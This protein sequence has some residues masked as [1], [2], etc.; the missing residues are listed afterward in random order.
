MKQFIFTAAL[1]L[2]M[3][4]QAQT[5]SIDRILNEIEQ[6]NKE[7]KA[8]E[9]LIQSQK[10]EAKTDNNLP[11]PTVSY[12]HLW[13]KKNSD[14]TVS[15]MVISQ[16]FDFPTLY[17]SRHK[18]NKLK[19]GTFDGQA[20]IIRR[21]LLLQAKEVCLDI[22][23]LRRQKLILDERLKNAQQLSNMYTQRLEAGDANIIE[24]NKINLELLNVKTE[25]TMN[26]TTLQNKMKE[27]RMLN[28]NEVI[29]FEE[30][31]Y[32]VVHFPEN[33]QELKAEVIATDFELQSINKEVAAARQQV[34]VN[35]SQWL[36]KLELGYR[37]NTE[38]GDPFNG[39]VVGFSIPI[40]EN[41]N[42]VKMAKAQ[43]LNLSYQK[44]NTSLQIESELA[45]LYEE[46][47]ALRSSM[48][49]YEKTFQAQSD[50]E[51][52]KQALTGGEISMIEYFVEVS[53]IY[54]SKLN[55]LE[56]QNQ[57]QKAMAKI[58]RNRL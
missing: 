6:N 16:S 34:T 51:L 9:S 19:M 20:D 23:M 45:Q 37:R 39:F 2:T 4:A 57:Y 46:A 35:K 11:D 52:L 18:L 47:G 41:K 33:L 54:Q 42:K 5:S 25:A 21:D 30:T 44:E 38:S 36:P 27:L 3:G 31:D 13:G 56:L 43:T 29:V 12:A 26:E 14:A 15:E 17:A 32:P 7:L 48:Q 1:F 58:Y 8:N 55:Y 28:G 10:L 22:I 49:E 53:V 40:F 24:T 50:L